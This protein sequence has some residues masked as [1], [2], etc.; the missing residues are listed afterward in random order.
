MAGLVSVVAAEKVR[1]RL[2]SARENVAVLLKK[3]RGE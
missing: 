2:E 3:T 1:D